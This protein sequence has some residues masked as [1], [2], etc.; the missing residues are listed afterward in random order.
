MKIFRFVAKF[1]ARGNGP[2]PHLDANS[3][4][5]GCEMKNGNKI[6]LFKLAFLTL[7]IVAG[8]GEKAYR[9]EDVLTGN[10]I[11]GDV[12]WREITDLASS[13]PIRKNG[14]AVADVKIPK[15]GSRC[16]G[17]MISEDI[18]M[19]NHH[20][21]P[22]SSYAVGVTA[23][24][25][26]EAGVSESGWKK[27]NCSTFIGN[28]QVLDYA[29]LRCAGSPGAEF[30]ILELSAERQPVGTSIYII[31]QNCDYFLKNGCDHT[32]KFSQGKVIDFDGEYTHNADTLGGSSGSPMFDADTHEV[33]GL[34][35]AGFANVGFG[36]GSENYAVAMDKIVK[37]VKANFPGVLSSGTGDAKPV[38]ALGDNDVRSRATTLSF[39]SSK[40]ERIGNSVDRDYFKVSLFSRS[41]LTVTVD[42]SH[43]KGDLDI[44]LENRSGKTLAKS[45]TTKN[46]EKISQTLDAGIYYVKVIG[47]R[48]AEGEYKIKATKSSSLSTQ[49]EREGNNT[50][51]TAQTISR[52]PAMVGEVEAEDVDV[53]KFQAKRNESLKP[54]LSFSHS[55]G[56]LDL[57]LLNSKS[58]IIARSTSTKSLESFTY[59][60]TKTESLF[61]V[62]IGY[63]GATGSY[64]L[65]L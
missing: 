5:G 55:H 56:D 30:G 20:C 29:L 14:K 17:F 48:G 38:D 34:H 33:I 57:Y 36:R 19:T 25:K 21:I 49:T 28:N 18:L 61:L 63:Q 41:K 26:H 60:A 53:F 65:K 4:H 6:K 12:D 13:H 1:F 9:G 40:S 23:A 35:H 24:F 44:Y 42:F 3:G 64:Q 50:L 16:T 62:V 32:K 37:S 7:F 58:E 11:I 43:S 10:V 46:Q 27:R 47:Y 2:N 59:K 39:N 31:Q 45:E 22:D 51:A 8:C 15:I 52:G 54:Q